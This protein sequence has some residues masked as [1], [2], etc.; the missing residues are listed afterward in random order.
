MHQSAHN[1]RGKAA[2]EILQA[3][4]IYLESIINSLDPAAVERW[5]L[6]LLTDS[7]GQVLHAVHQLVQPARPGASVAHGDWRCCSTLL[8]QSRTCCWKEGQV[9]LARM[10]C[11]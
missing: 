11:T 1:S 8:W 2:V 4:G 10:A 6:L 9:G 7:S 5:R 3:C